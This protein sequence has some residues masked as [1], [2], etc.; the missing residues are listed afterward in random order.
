MYEDGLN[1]CTD[2]DLQRRCNVLEEDLWR[3][4]EENLREDGID[5]EQETVLVDGNRGQ[6]RFLSE[7]DH[8]SST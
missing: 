4:F 7:M 5:R 8:S 1:A 3:I 6:I 2:H